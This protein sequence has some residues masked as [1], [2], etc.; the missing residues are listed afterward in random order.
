MAK[1]SR[2]FLK[3]SRSTPVVS[4]DDEPVH[5]A[6]ETLPEA[7]DD[8]KVNKSEEIRAEADRLKANG[9]EVRPK[10]IVENLAKKGIEVVSPLVS[11]VLKRHGVPQRPR[12]TKAKEQPTKP[13]APHKPS[14]NDT[15]NLNE[16]LAAK[17]FADMVGSSSK[18]RTLLDALDKIS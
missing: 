13:A 11:Q 18:A 3:P 9:Q 17:Q 15:F 8:T 2:A 6:T 12:K 7:K 14:S 10:T 1:K 5:I 16:L 4:D